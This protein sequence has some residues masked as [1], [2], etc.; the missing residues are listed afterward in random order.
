MNWQI[1]NGFIIIC[2]LCINNFH[3][4]KGK[5]CTDIYTIEH[6]YSASFGP[7]MSKTFS[8]LFLVYFD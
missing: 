7:V 3:G 6:K 4:F 5:K 1:Q 8:P 2:H